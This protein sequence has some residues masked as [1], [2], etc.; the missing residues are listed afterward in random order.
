MHLVSFVY[1]VDHRLNRDTQKPSFRRP[2]PVRKKKNSRA[3]AGDSLCSGRRIAI[4]QDEA[5]RG[6]R[7]TKLPISC[8][9]P[10]GTSQRARVVHFCTT[11]VPFSSDLDECG[12]NLHYI[13]TVFP[14]SRRM[15]C[16]FALHE[17]FPAFHAQIGR[18]FALHPRRCFA[19][20]GAARVT[21][22]LFPS[23]VE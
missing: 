17:F 12:V 1:L 18:I 13:C 20:R 9:S 22:A 3:T 19:R 11:F 14:R 8:E 5:A 6:K 10:S 7:R 2:W 4:S 21:E 16:K 23:A 15:W